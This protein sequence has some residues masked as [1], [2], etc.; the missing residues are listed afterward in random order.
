VNTSSRKLAAVSAGLLVL[1]LVFSSR[2]AAQQWAGRARIEGKVT[3]EK[4]EPIADAIVKLRYQKEGPDVKTGKN[5]RWAYLGLVG[6]SWDVDVAAPGYEPFKTTVQLSEINRLP[7]MDIKLKAEAPRVAPPPEVPKSVAPDVIP[8]LQKGNELLEA[9][10][11]A[12]ARAQYE[13]ALEIVPDNP[14]ILRGIARAQY[15][16]NKKDE[17]I[18]T[19]KKV[20]EKEP[21]DTST[22]LLLADLQVEQGQ[23]EDGKATL[24]KVPP[25]A[26][27]DPGIYINLGV[28]MLNKKLP[29]D[30][31]EQFDKAVRMKPDDAESYFY[32]GLA[33]YQAKRKAEAKADF[34][35]YLELA[36]NGEQAKDAK[37]LLKSIK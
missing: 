28:V 25:D 8:I 34:T 5:G 21:G 26:I 30:A 37:D 23:L 24:A 33:A 17:A 3:N 16:E 15:G 22:A 20:L 11:Y 6:G 9:K 35:K 19:L 14:A 10:D 4:G 31:W 2:A 32:R 27:K 12:G 29:Q 36:P 13:K 1:C 18:A 7:P